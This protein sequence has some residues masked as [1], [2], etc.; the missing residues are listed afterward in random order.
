L[1]LVSG[2]VAAEKGEEA[3]RLIRIS[4]R[5]KR[6]LLNDLN[7]AMPR[8]WQKIQTSLLDYPQSK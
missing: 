2:G 7:V 8:G 3:K 4:E 5:I 1:H 6:G